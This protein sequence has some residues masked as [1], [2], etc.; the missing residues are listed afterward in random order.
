M[1]L[2]YGKINPFNDPKKLGLVMVIFDDDTLSYEFDI[3]AFF[4]APDGLVY[5]LQDCGCSCPEPF[6]DYYATDTVSAI[7]MM[8]RVEN[9]DAAVAALWSWNRQ[10]YGNG[11]KGVTDRDEL[12]LR[13]FWRAPYDLG[14][15]YKP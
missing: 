6:E 15:T 11:T 2:D 3:L 14:W 13:Q 5:S 12:V 7:Q 1:S 8:S 4:K 10:E 9:L